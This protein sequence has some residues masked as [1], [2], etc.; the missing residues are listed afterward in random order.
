MFQN[1]RE[2]EDMYVEISRISSP[3]NIYINPPLLHTQEPKWQLKSDAQTYIQEPKCAQISHYQ[4]INI[5][6]ESKVVVK[7]YPE[8]KQEHE[9]KN[10]I[11]A[12]GEDKASP[13]HR[14]P[15]VT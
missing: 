13:I 6:K 7:L 3:S 10:R 15:S 12:E 9:V 14:S 2:H 1:N 8:S 4:T 5:E 11:S